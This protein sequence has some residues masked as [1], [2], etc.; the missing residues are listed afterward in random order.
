M[1]LAAPAVA[2]GAEVWRAF[3]VVGV[4]GGLTTFSTFS[5]FS[6][7]IVQRL[8]DGHAGRAAAGVAAHLLGSL[9][10]TSA[11]FRLA[12]APNRAPGRLNDGGARPL[13]AA[14]QSGRGP[15]A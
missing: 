13:G 14:L 4:L 7:G 2:T 9:A 10:A 11:A 5:N 8:H 3:A 15:G 1:L 6:A 12:A